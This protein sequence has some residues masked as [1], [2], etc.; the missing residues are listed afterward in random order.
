MVPN[1]VARPIA[2]GKAQMAQSG[3]GILPDVLNGRLAAQTRVKAELNPALADLT[4]MHRPLASGVRIRREVNTR[5]AINSR[6]WEGLPYQ[7][8][9]IPTSKDIA[10]SQ[11]PVVLDMNPINS[12]TVER[13]Y[14][15]SVSYF[16]DAGRTADGT[17]RRGESAGGTLPGAFM[18]NPY[19][20][21]LDAV[22]DSRNINRELRGT[23][24]EDNKLLQL[25]TSTRLVERNFSHRWVPDAE[26]R[27]N[28]ELEAYE[29]L[30]PKV[31]SFG[32][33]R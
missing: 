16:P 28:T 9:R 15:T 18:D 1:T 6:L 17:V 2:A 30:R 25:D 33:Y 7:A 23:V 24:V 29:L 26:K 27:Q 21:R 12:R 5:D 13:S 4:V 20:Q 11:K 14:A 31:D 19:L 8:A 22:K 32:D 10:E 3:E